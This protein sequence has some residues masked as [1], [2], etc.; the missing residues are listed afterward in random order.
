M[1]PSSS[2]SPG[3]ADRQKRD[4]NLSL[5]RL[6]V[7]LLVVSPTLR[8][9]PSVAFVDGGGGGGRSPSL[10][11]AACSRCVTGSST[12][13]HCKH[14]SGG[15]ESGG[16]ACYWRRPPPP[17]RSSQM[18]GNGGQKVLKVKNQCCRSV[19]VVRYAYTVLTSQIIITCNWNKLIMQMPAHGNNTGTNNIVTKKQHLRAYLMFYPCEHW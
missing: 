10:N 1:P 2:S 8:T 11:K 17:P 7:E 13:G 19:S 5:G 14:E 12:W 16:H 4:W 3:R 9:F 6:L 18:D 15:H